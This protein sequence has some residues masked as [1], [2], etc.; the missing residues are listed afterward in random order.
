ADDR[1]ITANAAAP[2]PGSIIA[3]EYEVKRHEWI[4]ELDWVFQGRSPVVQEVLTVQFPPGWEYR[5]AW[6]RGTPVASVQIGANRWQ[7]TLKNVQGIAQ[8]LEV[9]MP[10]LMSLAGRMSLSYFAPGVKSTHAASWQ[11]VG[12]WYAQLAEGRFNPTPEISAKTAALIAG[13]L[14]FA[15]RL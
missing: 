6:A 1:S 3:V 10:S 4:N 9:M 2:L 15:S 11:D 14:D 12:R 13:K 5:T 8:E 7:W